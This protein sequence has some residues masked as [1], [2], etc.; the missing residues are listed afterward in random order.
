MSY[1]PDFQVFALTDGATEIPMLDPHLYWL[2]D[3]GR[4]A[5][6]SG[7]PISDIRFKTLQPIS[8]SA[9]CELE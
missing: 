4:I 8:A 2:I 6:D 7:R 1:P 3:H 9:F 5:K